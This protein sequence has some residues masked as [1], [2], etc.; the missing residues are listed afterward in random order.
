MRRAP[1]GRSARGRVSGG[2]PK[3]REEGDE[4]PEVYQ[5]MLAEAELRNP[6]VS[7]ADRPIKRRKVGAQ[8]AT[9]SNDVSVPQVPLSMEDQ[10]QASRQVQTVYDEPTSEESDMEWEEVDLQQVPAQSTQIGPVTGADNEPLQIT[11]DSHEGKR[12]KVISRQKP[13]TAAEKKL[14]LDIHKVHVLCLLRHVQIRNLWCNDDELQSFL[15]RMLPKQVIAMLNPPEDKP[16]YS[17]STTFVEGLNQASD[18]FSRRFRVTRPG[19]KR[20]HWVDD[21]EKL[22]Q[23]VETIMFDAEVFLSEEDFCKQARTM[24]GSRDFGAQLFCALLRS[25]A[26]EAR[27]V[28]SLQ[29]LP[30]SGTTKSMTPNKRDSQYIV[31]SSDDHETSADDQQMSGL[32][33]TP[34][35][36][37][38]RLGRPQFT[39][40]RSQKTS[41]SGPGFTARASPYPVFWVEAF[42]EA[43]Q[44]WVPVDPL[45]TK[46]IAKPSKF[47]PPFSDPSNCMVYVVGFEEDASARDVTRRYAKAFNAKTRK[48]RVESTKDGERWW[49]RTMRFYEKPFLEDRDEVEISELTA[50]TA[51]EPMPRNVQDFKD[52]PIYAIERQLR[53]NEVVFPKR[54]IGQ[55]SLGKSGSKD[56]VLVPVYRRSDVHVVRSA[57]K[58]YR[59]G[60]DIKI[61]EQPLKRI[62]VNRNKDVGFSEDEHDNESGME[63]PLYAYFQTEVYTPP[64]VV[65]GKVP[66]NTYG[67][68]DVYVPSM[69]PPGGVHI[70]HPQAAHAA[71]VLGIDY[72]DAVTG[73]DFKGRHGTAVFQ[74]VIVASECQEAV[75]EVL[76]YLEDERRQAESEEKSRETLR[77]WKHFLLKLRIAERVKSYAIEGE[78]SAEEISENYEDPEEAGG[79]FIPEPE[80]EMAD[81]GNFST[82]QRS[83]EQ[84]ARVYTYHE[85]STNNGIPGDEAHGGGLKSDESASHIEAISVNPSETH[86]PKASR[87]PRYSLIVVPNKKANNNEDG[88]SQRQPQQQSEPSPEIVELE[89]AAE[90]QSMKR[91][92]EPSHPGSSEAPITVDSSTTG[93]SKSASIEVLS[94]AASQT[95]SRT[96]TPEE[97]DETSGVDD[98]GSLLSHDPE[99]EDAIPEW[100]V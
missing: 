39:P 37:S 88:T 98:N 8:R 32:S 22:K 16:Q 58:W 94:R 66:K 24:Q 45:V 48:M 19:L 76:D 15:K 74:G 59:L 23:K 72:A 42:N 99:D 31:I 28:C 78:E 56:Q 38:R 50:K 86:I 5:E 83:T 14:R 2:Q 92:G 80:Q 34:V 52:H 44:K 79:G 53:R 91:S 4:I 70:K 3:A 75:E 69:V 90:A 33:P 87:R 27:L 29:P 46:S 95:Q 96:P 89:P 93:G 21:P 40:A 26:V 25:A 64:P 9:T 49:A 47:E 12:R 17:R 65:Q 36:R 54:V 20:A 60:R 7:E 73:F 51:A 82:Y 67:N 30:F 43:V 61:G 6:D 57:D 13:L 55:V 97:M 81:G 85:A 1:R 63:I 100:L 35:S 11:L 10:G 18:A 68:L 71:R 62:R 77:L 84:E 41:I